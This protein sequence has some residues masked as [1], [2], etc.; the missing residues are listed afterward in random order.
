MSVAKHIVV[1]H[2]SCKALSPSGL[3]PHPYSWQDTSNSTFA[4]RLCNGVKLTSTPLHKLILPRILR[5]CERQVLLKAFVDN[6]ITGASTFSEPLTSKW[7]GFHLITTCNASRFLTIKAGI[8]QAEQCNLM[9]IFL[10]KAALRK[11]KYRCRLIQPQLLLSHS[12]TSSISPTEPTTHMCNRWPHHL[13]RG[14]GK[15]R[16][17]VAMNGSP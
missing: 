14:N 12:R 7:R 15:R 9:A 5:D 10:T 1:L 11:A 8:F 2:A 6:G 13:D 3:G 17:C 16:R 4:P